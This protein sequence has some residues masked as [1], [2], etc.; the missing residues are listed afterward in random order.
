MLHIRTIRVLAKER[1]HLWMS[2][3]V[4]LALLGIGLAGVVDN[5]WP[6]LFHLSWKV[7]AIWPLM[8]LETYPW[9]MVVLF[10]GILMGLD[11]LSVPNALWQRTAIWWV[12]FF[13][14]WQIAV[15]AGIAVVVDDFIKPIGA[16]FSYFGLAL[17]Y[18]LLLVFGPP[19]Y[20]EQL[21]VV[22]GED[23]HD[24]RV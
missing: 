4:S 23:T 13:I 9:S 5:L 16:F 20:T 10:G 24:G 11:V 2:I 7:A 14:L 12:V 3:P 15:Y 18:S 22:T 17:S 21:T 1:P 8:Y 6:G 19:L